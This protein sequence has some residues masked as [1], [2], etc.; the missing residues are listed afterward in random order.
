MADHIVKA[1]PEDEL[2]MDNILLKD[3]APDKTALIQKVMNGHFGIWNSEAKVVRDR[4]EAGEIFEKLQK[5]NA[6]TKAQVIGI[7]DAAIVK[8]IAKEDL[9]IKP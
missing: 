9:L 8:P 6:E 5:A 3:G 1:T 4:G 2:G 7:L